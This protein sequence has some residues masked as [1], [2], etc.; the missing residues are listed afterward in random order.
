MVLFLGLLYILGLTA[1][2]LNFSLLK[3]WWQAALASLVV[4][5]LLLI[6]YP[7]CASIGIV[8]LQNL[9]HDRGVINNCALFQI[10]ESFFMLILSNRFIQKSLN[11]QKLRWAV[12]SLLPSLALI[13]GNAV[14]L[15]ILFQMIN[16]KPFPLIATI[17]AVCIVTILMAGR[18]LVQ[19]SIRNFDSKIKGKIFILFLQILL[20]MFLP[21]L[22]TGIEIIAIPIHY[23]LLFTMIVIGGMTIVALVGFFVHHFISSEKGNRICRFLI[24][25]CT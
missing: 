14:I 24:R 7:Y 2:L 12:S 23:D 5:A 13:A 3:H 4:C 22:V 16:G 1:T 21:L 8:K 19:M 20:A 11:N 25:V 9:L 15:I 17:A 6:M 10:V 18:A